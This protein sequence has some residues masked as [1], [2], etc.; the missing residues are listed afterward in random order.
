LLYLIVDCTRRINAPPQARFEPIPDFRD[1]LARAR[2]EAGE[3]LS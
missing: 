1:R 3:E 2:G